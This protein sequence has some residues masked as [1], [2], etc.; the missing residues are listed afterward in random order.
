MQST[1]AWAKAVQPLTIKNGS[2]IVGSDPHYRPG[3]SR[4]TAH[5]AMVR[6]CETSTNLRA[7]IMNGDVT[8]FPSISKHPSIGWED[9]PTVAAEIA[10][11]RERLREFEAFDTVRLWT[12]GNHDLRFETYLAKVAGEYAEIEGFHLHDHFPEWRPCWMVEVNGSCM[13]KH[14]WKSGLHAAYN[15]TLGAGRTIVTGHLHS[16]KVTPYTDYNGTRWGVDTGT[17]AVPYDVQFIDY[18]EA[19]P[20]NWRSAVTVLTWCDGKLLPPEQ[21]Y[22]LDEPQRLTVF[23]GNIMLESV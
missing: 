15:N 7:I 9:R 8:D 11:C 16:A 19:N 22:V 5:A 17:L 20:V 14:R 21:L 6:L 12:A 2:I 23:R 18:T 10:I 4:S 13:I 1:P 3:Q